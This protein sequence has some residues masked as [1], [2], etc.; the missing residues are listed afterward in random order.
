MTQWPGIQAKIFLENGIDFDGVEPSL[1]LADH[2]T[3]SIGIEA[4]NGTFVPIIPHG[5]PL[6]VR[7]SVS[8]G[9]QEDQTEAFVAVYQ[10][11]LI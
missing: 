11:I 7:R 3:K 4:A 9:I 10:G 8:F 1:S 2:L 6:P 5:T